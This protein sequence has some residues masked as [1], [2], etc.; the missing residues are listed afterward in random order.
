ME[1]DSVC[2]SVQDQ[3]TWSPLI[4]CKYQMNDPGGLIGS[5][6]RRTGLMT[7][8]TYSMA[9]VTSTSNPQIQENS[10]I[11]EAQRSP[12]NRSSP[13]LFTSSFN[14]LYSSLFIPNY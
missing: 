4:I 9:E 2:S 10:L 12:I 1:S 8:S 13:G 7:G 5:D 6:N 11:D 14:H 3:W